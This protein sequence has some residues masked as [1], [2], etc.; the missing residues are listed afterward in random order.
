MRIEQPGPVTPRITLL[1]RNESCVYLVDGGDEYALLG[2]G[3]TYIVPDIL[4]QIDE[5]GV[6][7]EKIRRLVIHHSHFDHVG[8]VPRLKALWPWMAVTASVRAKEML[9]RP[10][11]VGAISSLNRMLLP[12]TAPDELKKSLDITTIG[13]DRTAGDGDLVPCGDLDLEMIEVP[14]HSSCSMAVYI[15][16]EKVL[17][18]SDAGGIPYG[19]DIFAAANSNFDAYQASLEKMAAYEVEVVLA[20]HYGAVAG[21]AGRGF[22]AKSIVRAREMRALLEETYGRCRDE[23]KAVAALLEEISSRASGYFLPR[24]VMEMVLGQMVRFMAKQF[25]DRK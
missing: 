12:D 24:E 17:S 21:D 15:P 19:E 3:M 7:P 4:R 8:I 16:A 22:M 20:E 1:G 23:K 11:V 25:G 2:G 14:G 13:V 18:P 10:D 9:A 6:D 5:L